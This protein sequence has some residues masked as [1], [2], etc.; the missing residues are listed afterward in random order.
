M[1][2][3]WA[4]QVLPRVAREPPPRDTG[5]ETRHGEA[6][7]HGGE[8]TNNLMFCTCSQTTASTIIKV[9]SLTRL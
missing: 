3:V 8:L 4:F 6:H 1:D 2:L 7:A 9:S 5:D